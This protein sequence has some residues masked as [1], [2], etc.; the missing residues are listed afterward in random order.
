MQ[1][2]IAFLVGQVSNGHRVSLLLLVHVCHV[3]AAGHSPTW[4]ITGWL[5]G[6]WLVQG[7]RTSAITLREEAAD[8]LGVSAIGAAGHHVRASES[9]ISEA[10]A[11][12][13]GGAAAAPDSL[14]VWRWMRLAALAAPTNS[15]AGVWLCGWGMPWLLQPALHP[16]LDLCHL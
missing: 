12:A 1:T 7:L 8:V 14:T 9:G 2:I 11:P 3:C 6:G 16:V 5:A 13:A 10:G 4:V 15:K